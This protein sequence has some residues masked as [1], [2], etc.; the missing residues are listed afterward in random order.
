MPL[1][2]CCK[3]LFDPRTFLTHHQ[4]Y[5]ESGN[6]VYH[7]FLARGFTPS[8]KRCVLLDSFGRPMRKKCKYHMI[9]R[10]DLYQ[11]KDQGG[12]GISNTRMM[13][14]ALVSKWIWEIS[15][16]D[17]GLWTRILKTKYFP[18]CSFFASDIKGSQIWNEI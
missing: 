17:D 8:L 11:P 2:L 5:L 3:F 4:K 13:N 9:R 12:L 7:S 10:A 1:Y 16:N 15:Q 14:L 6:R 18:N